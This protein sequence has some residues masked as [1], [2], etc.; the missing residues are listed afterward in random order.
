M[1]VLRDFEIIKYRQVHVPAGISSSLLSN[2]L[3]GD[4]HVEKS[5]WKLTW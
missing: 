1:E 5:W 3:W 4:C 2:E